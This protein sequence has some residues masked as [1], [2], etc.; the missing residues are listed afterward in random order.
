MNSVTALTT[1]HTTA[2]NHATTL[3][4]LDMDWHEEAPDPGGEPAGCTGLHRPG[5]LDDA[6]GIQHV[7]GVEALPYNGFQ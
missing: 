3:K 5:H 2:I 4:V 6:S 7:A 1:S